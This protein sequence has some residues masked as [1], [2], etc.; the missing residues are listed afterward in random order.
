MKKKE[1]VGFPLRD[2]A[3]NLHVDKQGID[4]V[5]NQHFVTVFNQLE[6][7][8]DVIWHKYWKCIDEI[9]QLLVSINSGESSVDTMPRKD[10]VFKIISGM[11][12][13]KTV[14]GDM[15]IDLVKLAGERLW[16]VIFRFF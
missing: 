7:H 14:K 3:G 9:Y 11:D 6:V 15:T 16:D 1:V 10:D 4:K 2:Q 5:I 12:R 13:T 8:D